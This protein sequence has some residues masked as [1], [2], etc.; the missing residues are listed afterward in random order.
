MLRP[1]ALLAYHAVAEVD[2]ADDPHRLVTAPRFLDQ[3]VALLQRLGYRFLTAEQLL[4]ET[5]GTRPTSGVAVLTFDDGWADAVHTVLPLL[6]RRGVPAT[7][8]VNPAFF[9]GTHSL[10]PGDAGRLLD[11][12]GVRT[13]VAEGME[14]ASHSLA[15]RDLRELPDEELRD[16]LVNSKAAV[17]AVTGRPCRTL[18]YP[19][20]ALDE[21]VEAAARDAR[22]ELAFAWRPGRWRRWAAPRLP[23]PPRHGAG[24]LA[25][26]LLGVR[27]RAA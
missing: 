20:G 1:P 12:E 11:A 10:V 25:L 8:Y 2:E 9:G 17:E 3:Q 7:F 22:Y 6:R 13:L 23:A 21:R 16:D 15:H 19:F 18:A 5:G 24:R 27:R 14:V 4:D 26:K